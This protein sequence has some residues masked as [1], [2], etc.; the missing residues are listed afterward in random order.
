MFL[1]YT[2][3]TLILHISVCDDLRVHGALIP[4]KYPNIFESKGTSGKK[5]I[6]MKLSSSM[7]AVSIMLSVGSWHSKPFPEYG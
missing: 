4:E 2:D 7:I 5:S 6:D 1:L 3:V